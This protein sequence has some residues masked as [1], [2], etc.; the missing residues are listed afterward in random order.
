MRAHTHVVNITLLDS[1]SSPTVIE[2]A[3]VVIAERKRYTREAIRSGVENEEVVGS[4]RKR[5]EKNATP[6]PVEASPDTNTEA[7]E[8]PESTE[9]AAVVAATS[10]PRAPNQEQKEF[11][12][13]KLFTADPTPK[14]TP[15]SGTQ[16]S[17]ADQGEPTTPTDYWRGA[18]TATTATPNTTP[19]RSAHT[20]VAALERPVAGASD[21][22]ERAI[23]KGG[24]PEEKADVSEKVVAG[25]HRKSNTY[26]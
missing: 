3:I 20:K 24:I 8:A 1:K 21:S 14:S 16:T 25:Q 26:S 13:L 10:N 9:V 17:T 6:I 18:G 7:P 12:N 11:A 4:Q 22:A 2:V 5:E 23:S 19:K 15:N